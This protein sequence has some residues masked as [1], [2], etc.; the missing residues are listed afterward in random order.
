MVWTQIEKGKIFNLPC[1]SKYGTNVLGLVVI[2]NSFNVY[3]FKINNS[4]YYDNPFSNGL[5][6]YN[7]ILLSL[8]Q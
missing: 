1:M 5:F 2:R 6:L 8:V 3:S 7:V 4:T